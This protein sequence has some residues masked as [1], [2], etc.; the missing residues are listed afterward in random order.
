MAD[1]SFRL[2]HSSHFMLPESEED[3][4]REFL[5]RSWVSFGF[6]A[7][8]LIIF[9]ALLAPEKPLVHANICQQHNSSAACAVW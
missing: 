3:S 2:K 7:A 8:I 6:I 9:A 1:S 4:S 5:N